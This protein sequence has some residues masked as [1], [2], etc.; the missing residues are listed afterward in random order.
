MME[1]TADRLLLR[2]VRPRTESC[3]RPKTAEGRAKVE[4]SGGTAVVTDSV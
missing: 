1:G 4:L 3:V 2:W